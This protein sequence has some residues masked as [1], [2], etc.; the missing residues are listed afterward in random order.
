M[1]VRASRPTEAELEVLSVLWQRG[2]STVRQVH[3]TLQADHDTIMTTTL[4]TMQ[5]MMAKGLLKRKKEG[6]SPHVYTPAAPEEKTQQQLL[7]NLV[8]RAFSGSA[9][10]M[11]IRAVSDGDLDDEELWEIRRLIDR[12]RKEQRG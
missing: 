9:R 7:D 11:L 8:Q 1:P 6:T 10:K 12:I 3:E 2:P 4:K 5:V